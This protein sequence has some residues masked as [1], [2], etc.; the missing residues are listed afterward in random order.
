MSDTQP[1]NQPA[2]SISGAPATTATAAPATAVPAHNAVAIGVPWFR[3]LGRLW[4]LQRV[5][6]EPRGNPWVLIVVLALGWIGAWVFID[7]WQRQ[8]DPE[9]YV[10]GIPLFGWYVMAVLGLAQWLKWQSSSSP[11]LP[12]TL[13]LVLGMVPVPLLWVSVA[14]YYLSTT[15]FWGAGMVAAVYLLI[16]LARGLRAVT[17]CSQWAAAVTGLMFVAAFMWASNAVNAIPD[18]WNPRDAGAA[19]SDDMLAERE[20]ALFE[21][22]DRIDAALEGVQRDTSPLPEGFF[23]G[24]A[25]VGDEKVFAQ[26][27]G[28]ASRVVGERFGIGDR[29]LSLVNDERDLERAPLASV[30][31]LTYALHALASRM[32]LDKDVLFLSISSHG[33]EDPAIAVSN[34]QFPLRDLTAEDLQEALRDAGIKWRVIII[35]A[36]YAGGFID[37]LRDPQTIIITAAAADRT[38]FGCSNDSDL[39]YFGEAFY[40]DALPKANSLR[41]A[42]EIAKKAIAAREHDE[43]V[44]PSNPQAHFGTA[45]ESKLDAMKAATPPLSRQLPL[46]TALPPAGRS[47]AE[48]AYLRAAACRKG[49]ERR[50]ISKMQRGSS[51]CVGTLTTWT[52]DRR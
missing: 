9:F 52:S 23:L 13:I 12:A 44:T 14:S 34:S 21:Q 15:W 2:E 3:A 29:H 8:P 27:I 39:T 47:D 10:E 49:D 38:S 45:L 46:S 33:S 50:V 6:A 41:D 51:D 37:S 1:S 16:Y 42:F 43:N 48:A 30:S 25:G 18:V 19:V 17:G 31:G 26:E 11:A 20:L 40:R 36:C 28:L 5:D 4:L 7:R 32:D 24:F 35:S 22:A